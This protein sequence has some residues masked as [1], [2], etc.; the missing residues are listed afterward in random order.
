MIADSQPWRKAL[1]DSTRRLQA[2]TLQRRWTEQ[3][4]YL[5]ERDLLLGAFSVRKLSESF[6]LSDEMRATRIP[7]S[8]HI[9]SGK[10]PDLLNKFEI[11]KSF[12][13]EVSLPWQ[14]GIE[15]LCNQLIHSW[16]LLPN[17]DEESRLFD[18]L[19]F[20][21]DRRRVDCLYFVQASR[22]IELFELVVCDDIVDAVMTRNSIGQMEYTRF[23]SVPI[24]AEDVELTRMRAS[25]RETLNRWS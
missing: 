13:L 10:A 15:E 18:G 9:R 14:L 5:L 2:K 1:L 22:L 7:V 3:S 4:F 17:F 19:Y 16:T 21:S 8:K 23:S 25:Q 12:D 24:E 11:W 6:K 20:V